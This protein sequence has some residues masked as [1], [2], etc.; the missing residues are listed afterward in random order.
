MSQQ[1]RAANEA[2][3]AASRA[4]SDFLANMSNEIRTAMT[5]ILGFSDL[6]QQSEVTSEMRAKEL[7]R[8]AGER[9]GPAAGGHL[10]GGRMRPQTSVKS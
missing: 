3:E 7:C 8:Q 9:G 10:V 5:A 4:K 1:L 2:A 6:L